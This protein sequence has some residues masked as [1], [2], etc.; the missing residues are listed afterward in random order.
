MNRLT[1]LLCLLLAACDGTSAS[2]VISDKKA[3]QIGAAISGSGCG[4][5]CSN[6]LSI[7]QTASGILA[8]LAVVIFFIPSSSKKKND[9][10]PK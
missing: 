2:S 4:E 9:E 1:L 10:I 3:A 8:A 5:V 7:L 6:N